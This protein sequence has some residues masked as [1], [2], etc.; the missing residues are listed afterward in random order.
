M[1]GSDFNLVSPSPIPTSFDNND[2]NQ[3][4]L[5]SSTVRPTDEERANTIKKL[6]K[7][8]KESGLITQFYP[9]YEEE[10]YEVDE[11]VDNEEQE[12]KTFIKSS[13]PAP[14]RIRIP[15]IRPKFSVS[16]T[17]SQTHIG[18]TDSTGGHKL[19]SFRVIT[20]QNN[21]LF[22]AKLV[23]SQAKIKLKSI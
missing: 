23:S 17:S 3:F 8:E 7:D 22:C 21:R 4:T 1:S 14:N 11:E 9:D 13:T 15:N 12:R 18:F 5:R 2:D 20:I 19:L 16:A 6:M 10:D